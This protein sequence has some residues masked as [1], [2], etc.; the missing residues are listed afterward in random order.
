MS[1]GSRIR[2]LRK[3]KDWSQAQLAAKLGVHQKHVSRYETEECRPSFDVLLKIA[4]LFGVTTD[5]LLSEEPD[6]VEE[7]SAEP[8]PV[9]RDRDLLG[10]FEKVDRLPE[11]DRRLARDILEAILARAEVRKLKSALF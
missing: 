5:Y 2:H 8:L 11:D 4:E 3:N 10:L 1:L 9:I 6:P 7:E